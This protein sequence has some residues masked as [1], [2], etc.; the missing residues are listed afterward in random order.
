MRFDASLQTFANQN[1]CNYQLGCI[2]LHLILFHRLSDD[3]FRELVFMA[4]Y[5]ISFLLLHFL[6]MEARLFLYIHMLGTKVLI[7][8]F[9]PTFMADQCGT[10]DLALYLN[11]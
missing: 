10:S 4:S 2:L 3:S 1:F 5:I 9:C 8:C 7:G 11:S 6:S